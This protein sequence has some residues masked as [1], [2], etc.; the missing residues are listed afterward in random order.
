MLLFVVDGRAAVAPATEESFHV[1]YPEDKQIIKREMTYLV[2][3]VA[4]R[5]VTYVVVKVNDQLTPVIDIKTEEYE[6]Y[7]KGTIIVRTFLLPGSN[8]IEIVGRNKL[9][10]DVVSKKMTLF[11]QK[12]TSKG[13]M[14]APPE[15]IPGRMHMEEK[16]VPCKKCHRMKVDPV[17]DLDPLKKNDL[18]CVECHE[19][20]MTEFRPHGTATWKCLQCHSAEGEVKYSVKDREGVYCGGCHAGDVVRFSSMTSI[21]PTVAKRECMTCHAMHSERGEHLVSESVNVICFRCHKKHFTGTH[22]TPG[23]PMEAKKDPSR[24]GKEFNC[25]SCHSPHS[26]NKKKLMRFAP[27]MMMC[28]VCHAM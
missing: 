15:F 23:H 27:G 7:L 12:T 6:K 3:K 22:V 18:F 20:S 25:V 21:H 13:T 2:A 16:E 14:T 19:A 1:Y 5:R 28:Q 4:D 9:G 10:L 8:I 26:S 11:Y 24:K 17:V